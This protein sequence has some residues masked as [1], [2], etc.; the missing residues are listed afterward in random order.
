MWVCIALVFVLAS[1]LSD[2]SV[3]G[4]CSTKSCTYVDR[5]DS[6]HPGMCGTVA[7]DE[8]NCYCIELGGDRRAQ[9]QDTCRTK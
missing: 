5:G 2:C 1:V 6:A 4:Y 9:V 8:R 7:S 3:G